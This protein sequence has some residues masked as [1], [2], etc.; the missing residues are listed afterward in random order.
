[1]LEFCERWFLYIML[2][3]VGGWI[4][5]TIICSIEARRLVDRGFLNGPYCPI[6]GFGVL[7]D[8]LVIGRVEN[9]ALLFL[10]GSLID[11]L[12]EY[13]TSYVMEKLFHARW[14]DYS[15]YRFNINGRVCLLGAVVFGIFSMLV[16]KFVHPAVVGLIGMIAQPWLH[17]VSGV[18][19]VLVV[20]DTVVTVRGMA[21][22]NDKLRE[23]TAELE[24]TRERAVEAIRSEGG[25]LA[26]GMKK[27]LDTVAEARERAFEAIKSSPVYETLAEVYESFSAKLNAQQQRMIRSFPHLRSVPYEKTLTELKHFLHPKKK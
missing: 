9:V 6:Y 25:A 14:W 21:G 7:F 12:L 11:T 4:Y 22:F 5:E 26:E 13:V 2:Y 19:F 17:V 18:L 23:L 15:N 10:F 3:S 8:V 20:T 16:I 24:S 27:K 1:M